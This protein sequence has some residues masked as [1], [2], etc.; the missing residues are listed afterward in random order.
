M[1]HIALQNEGGRTSVSRLV[2]GRNENPD[3]T[4]LL[5]DDRDEHYI[6]VEVE[7]E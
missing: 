3:K 5:I 1:Y 6:E 4:V 7:V 2:L